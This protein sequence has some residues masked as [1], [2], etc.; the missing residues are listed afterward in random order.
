MHWPFGDIEILD[1]R[2]DNIGHASHISIMANVLQ[3]VHLHLDRLDKFGHVDRVFA[4][5]I[6]KEVE[7][8]LLVMMMIGGCIV[9]CDGIMVLFRQLHHLFRLFGD[10]LF[11]LFIFLQ[12]RMKQLRYVLYVGR[13]N[14][15]VRFGGR[16]TP[17]TMIPQT[18]P[19]FVCMTA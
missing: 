9:V 7:V 5:C 8:E 13:S 3:L 15:C 14:L 16:I 12:L 17:L 2:Q 4:R 19:G 6:E 18:A 1:P 10:E 11:Q